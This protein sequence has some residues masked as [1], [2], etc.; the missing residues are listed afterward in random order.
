VE[1]IVAEGSGSKT[2]SKALGDLERA[3]RSLSSRSMLIGGVSVIA[4]GVPRTTA[5]IDATVELLAA[6]PRDVDDARELLRLHGE[7]VDRRAVR[8]K[9]EGFAAELEDDEPVR[10]WKQLTR[11]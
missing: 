2:F 9:L 7:N 11:R 8:K 6:R 1:E 10:L 3:L 4:Y 5:D